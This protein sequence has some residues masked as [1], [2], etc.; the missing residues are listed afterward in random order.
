MKV[1]DK[2]KTYEIF[3][4]KVLIYVEY[5]KKCLCLYFKLERELRYFLV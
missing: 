1:N 3:K 5:V 4:K 2:H